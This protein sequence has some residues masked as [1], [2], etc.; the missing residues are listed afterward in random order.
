[1][2]KHGYSR[3]NLL[4]ICE[5]AFVP[6]A[7]WANRDSADAQRQLGEC[8]ALLKAGCKFAVLR[9]PDLMTDKR[10]IWVEVQYKGFAHLDYDGP[11]DKD[12]YYLPTL[13]RLDSAG[14]GK[15]WY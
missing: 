4:A 11:L 14:S 1:M 2:A 15:D 13:A 12:T 10:T 8:Y 3:E 5:G 7:E 6:E 9:G